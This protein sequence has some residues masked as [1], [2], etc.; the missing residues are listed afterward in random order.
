MI[1][2]LLA[3]ALLGCGLLTVPSAR[4]D[5]TT[6]NALPVRPSAPMDGYSRDQFGPPWTD[7]NDDE[8]GHN[9]CDT[10]DDILARDLTDVVRDGPCVVIWGVLHDPYTGR[11]IVFHRSPATSTRIQIDHIVP[12]ADAWRT[13]AQQLTAEQRTN[14]ANDPRNLLAV[15]GH[16]NTAKSDKDASQWLPPNADFRCAYVAKQIAV[17]AT[18]QLWVTPEERDAMRKVLSNC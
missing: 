15:E 9:H 13:G 2:R 14:L 12:L 7:N 6:L 18:Y 8:L 3:A 11:V 1:R 4:A 17:K 10:R 16:A 5:V